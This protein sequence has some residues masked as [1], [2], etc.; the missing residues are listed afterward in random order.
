[1]LTT[2][3]IAVSRRKGQDAQYHIMLNSVQGCTWRNRDR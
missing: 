3:V 2:A 1:L